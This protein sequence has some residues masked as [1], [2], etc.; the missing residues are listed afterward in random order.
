MSPRTARVVFP[1]LVVMVAVAACAKETSLAARNPHLI[2]E[3]QDFPFSDWVC[4]DTNA[5]QFINHNDVA[6][7]S[8]VV[9]TK[10]GA[11]RVTPLTLRTDAIFLTKRAADTILARYYISNSDSTKAR[12]L[13]DRLSKSP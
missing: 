9:K 11:T 2:C 8:L 10:S 13:R 7:M 3:H 4:S 1:A 6:E 5:S 12:G